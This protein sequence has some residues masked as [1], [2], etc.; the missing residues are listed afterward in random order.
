MP[1]AN[2]RTTEMAKDGALAFLKIRAVPHLFWSAPRPLTIRPPAISVAMLAVGLVL[3]GD[4]RWLHRRGGRLPLGQI[5][6]RIE[7]DGRA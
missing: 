3:F 4:F 1:R 7:R 5:G 6:S 2:K